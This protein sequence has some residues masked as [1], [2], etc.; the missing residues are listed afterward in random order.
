MFEISLF[1]YRTDVPCFIGNT[2]Y[3]AAELN[4]Y[5]NLSSIQIGDM[6]KL[7]SLIR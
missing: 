7:I 2:T 4:E 3:L 5:L 1:L 6:E